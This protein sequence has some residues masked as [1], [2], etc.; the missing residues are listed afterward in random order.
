MAKL[1]VL[2]G[3]PGAGKSTWVRENA[4]NDDH[5]FKTEAIRMNKD[6]NRGE[7]MAHVRMQAMYAAEAGKSIIADGTHT[8]PAHRFWWLAIAHKLEMETEL[9]IFTTPLAICLAVQDAREFPAPRSS[10]VNHWY[11]LKE[12][13]PKVTKETWNTISYRHWRYDA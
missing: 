5:I 11:R 2:M 9:I 3:P 10:V 4:T 1:T 6:I 12:E 13:T 7:Y 8:I